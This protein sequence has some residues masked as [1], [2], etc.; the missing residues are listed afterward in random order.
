M[1]PRKPRERIDA[2]AARELLNINHPDATPHDGTDEDAKL[3][4]LLQLR[5]MGRPWRGEGQP[6]E[7]WK[8][9]SARCGELAELHTQLRLH[10]EDSHAASRQEELLEEIAVEALAELQELKA[11]VKRGERKDLWLVS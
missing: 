8:A 9:S 10:P 1:P 11:A 2:E 6:D 5:I 3:F 4:F 7:E